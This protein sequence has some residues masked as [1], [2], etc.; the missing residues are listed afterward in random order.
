MYN[1]YKTQPF[2]Y[3]LE[4]LLVTRE[5]FNYALFYEQGLGKTKMSIDTASHLFRL[6]WIDFVMIVAPNDVHRNWIEEQL[7]VHL[8]DDVNAQSLAK[9]YETNR[10]GTKWHEQMLKVASEYPGLTWIA[11]SYDG[12][13][14]DRGKAWAREVMK[15]RNVLFI[16]DESHTIKTPNSGVTKTVRD[17]AKRAKFR[18]IL[19]GTPTDK[20]FDIYSQ[21]AAVDSEFWK[22]HRLGTFQEFKNMFGVFFQPI[23]P[24]TG[25]PE[26]YKILKGYK[27]LPYLKKKKKKISVRRTKEEELDLPPKLYSRRDLNMS[28]EQTRVYAE[29]CRHY[30]TEVEEG[31]TVSAEISLS[32]KGKLH[33]IACG[34]VKT[35]D[36]DWINIPG[37]NP[38]L[39]AVKDIVGNSQHKLIIFAFY[40]HEIT[41]I[42][43]TLKEYGALRFDGTLSSDENARNKELFKTDPKHQALVMQ[44]DKG[45]TGHN[46]TEAKTVVY[47]SNTFSYLTRAQSEDRAHRIGQDNP[48]L[49]VDLVMKRT[50]DEE[51]ITALRGKCDV[52]ST[53][54][55]DQMKE[56]I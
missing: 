41:L 47:F 36:G 30:I 24:L 6:G 37:K 31:V 18:R 40:T 54:V 17:L 16:M 34:F 21:I 19:T 3:Q 39:E 38:K 53:I 44:I 20:P 10:A 48:V 7:P 46:L 23:D 12:I 29:M 5:A 14:T 26:K 35:D 50:V 45:S 43:D 2:P 28:A 22:C 49:Y 25:L 1:E 51:I 4:D 15:K 56:W 55:G 33:Q 27:N 11:I 52:A 42:V 32:L 13:C 8:P 9:Y